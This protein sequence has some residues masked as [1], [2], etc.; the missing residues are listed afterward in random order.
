MGARRRRYEECSHRRIGGANR[1]SYAGVLGM[2]GL[3]CW[4]W[5][6]AFP[7]TDNGD[8]WFNSYGCNSGQ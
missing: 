1:Y 2:Y 6:R 8:I 7:F 5:R 3:Y 4:S